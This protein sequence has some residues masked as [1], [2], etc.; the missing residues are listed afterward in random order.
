MG[1]PLTQQTDVSSGEEVIVYSMVQA[2]KAV[3]GKSGIMRFAAPAAA[4]LNDEAF[5]PS[6]SQVM[7]E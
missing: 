3:A 7:N 6:Q 5:L 2:P 4:R 1:D